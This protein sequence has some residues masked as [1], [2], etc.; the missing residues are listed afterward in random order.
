[1]IKIANHCHYHKKHALELVLQLKQLHLDEDLTLRI[2]D[3]NI[4]LCRQVLNQQSCFTHSFTEQ[5]L[6]KRAAQ[7]NQLLLKACNNKKRE[8]HSIVDL[9]AG[10]GRDSFILATHGQ[11]IIMSEQNP[12]IYSCLNFLIKIARHDE[13]DEVYQ[14]LSVVNDNSVN[15]LSSKD[16][17]FADC[18][19]ID[20]MFPAH[21]SS[22]LPAK[23]LQILQ[24]LTN[25]LDIEELFELSLQKAKYRVVVKRPIHAKTL[26]DKKP[27]ITYKEKTIR[28]D[29]YLTNS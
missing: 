16:A 12:L 3:K 8:I 15:Y 24:I 1:M 19:Y 25:N 5:K 27:D 4:T 9:T 6:I 11:Q 29:V 22:A 7:K 2:E 13:I 28:F 20:P 23:D 14:R 17:G 18:L 10:W 26:S 21:K